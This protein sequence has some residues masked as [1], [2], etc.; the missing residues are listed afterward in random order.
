MLRIDL[1]QVARVGRVEVE[2]DVPPDSPLLADTDV[3]LAGPLQVRLEAQ[4]VGDGVVVRGTVT[5]DVRWECRRCLTEVVRT[6]SEEVAFLFE[7]EAS[8]EEADGELYALPERGVE[9]DV[10]EAVREHFVLA[11][12]RFVVCREGCRG[13]CPRCGKN[14]NEGPCDC[15]VDEVDE[16]WAP[17]RKLA[18]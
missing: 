11:V 12:P 3:T 5:G 9:L 8:A 18:D 1:V 13:L 15:E 10:G 17:L 14:L 2:A 6:V 7:D 4:E 16:R